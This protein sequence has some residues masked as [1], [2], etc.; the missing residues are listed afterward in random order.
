MIRLHIFNNLYPYS[1]M[2]M[3]ELK[4]FLTVYN[5]AIAEIDTA[6]PRVVSDMFIILPNTCFLKLYLLKIKMYSMKTNITH[7]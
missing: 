3:F 7:T 4:L 6:Q 5:P 1:T 2:V